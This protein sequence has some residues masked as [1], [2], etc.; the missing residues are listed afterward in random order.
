[1][2]KKKITIVVLVA[3]FLIIC[4]A[5]FI[6]IMTSKS[7]SNKIAKEADRTAS[8]QK[9][10]PAVEKSIKKAQEI[11]EQSGSIST[12][13][14]LL[15]IEEKYGKTGERNE[16]TGNE[17]IYEYVD[18]QTINGRDYYNFS[19]S[20]LVYDDDIA[21]HI[22]KLGNIMVAIDGSA[23][24]FAEKLDDKWQ[25]YDSNP[26]ESTVFVSESNSN[27][28]FS[29]TLVLNGDNTFTFSYDPLSSYLPYGK[30][31]MGNG[32]IVC[33]TS[34][35]AYTYI[36]DILD[37]NKVSFNAGLSSNITMTDE[38]ASCIENGTIYILSE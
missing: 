27:I 4:N 9:V 17:N 14:A 16:K 31:I 18:T 23:I 26:G 15:L 6:F 2:K 22:S 10:L 33:S 34:D 30:Y 3:I 7:A 20:W 8:S 38:T 29:S 24:S 28:D 11:Q 32:K 1:M 12:E 19:Y 37:D 21:S 35:G 25:L 13:S 36:F 5:V